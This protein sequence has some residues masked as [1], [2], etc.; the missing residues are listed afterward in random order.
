MP[1]SFDLLGNTVGGRHLFD[2]LL[3]VCVNQFKV[4]EEDRQQVLPKRPAACHPLVVAPASMVIGAVE[5]GAWYNSREPLEEL[6]VAHVHPKGDLRLA[7]VAPE[8][9]FAYQDSNQETL[10]E[11]GHD[12]SSIRG[13][14]FH[15]QVSRGTCHRVSPS[16]FTWNIDVTL[17][18]AVPLA[19]ENRCTISLMDMTPGRRGLR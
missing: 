2:P 12:R 18:A 13:G 15:C 8:M 4:S 10:F 6:L 19:A 17:E 14:L 1:L 9:P 7:P 16:C 11:L 5:P 3:H